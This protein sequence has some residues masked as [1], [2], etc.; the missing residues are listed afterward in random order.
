MVSSIILLN[1]ET[2]DFEGIIFEVFSAFGTVGLS[3]G[4]TPHLSVA[5]K[6][7]I[8]ILMFV[9]RLGPLTLAVILLKERAVLVSCPEEKIAVG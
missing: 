9:G 7:V 5:G 2:W 8:T 1:T 3:T 4:I 6:I